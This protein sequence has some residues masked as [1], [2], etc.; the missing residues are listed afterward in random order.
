MELE[1]DEAKRRSNLRKHGLDFDDAKFLD[2][3]NAT[4]VEDTRFAYSEPRYWAFARWNGRLHMVAFCIR[5][6]KVRV[7]SF[8]RANDREAR[9][10]GKD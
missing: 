1:W 4:I 2:W 9:R 6:D 8:R 3:D 10:H 5:G 7:I